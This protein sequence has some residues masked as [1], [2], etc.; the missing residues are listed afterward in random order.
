MKIFSVLIVALLIIFQAVGF[1]AKGT[2]SASGEYLMSDYDTP[3]IAEAIALDFAKQ[4][5][6]EQAGI[7]LESYSRSANFKLE[8]DEIKTV[9]SSKVEVLKK[10]ITRKPQRDGRILLRADIKATV[11][12][13]ELDN[14]LA[15][16]R[17]QRQGQ[18]QR[19]KE[20]QEMNAKIK[21]DI[22]TLQKKLAAIRNEVKDNDLI[23][24][25][26]RI[27]REFLSKQKVEEFAYKPFENEE[28]KY[29]ITRIKYDTTLIDE[30]IKFNPKNT[31]AYIL[32]AFFTSASSSNINDIN[33]ALFLTSDSKTSA[34]LYGFRALKYQQNGDLNRALEDYNKAI[35]LDPKS[36]TSYQIRASFYESRLKDYDKALADYTAAIK[37]NPKDVDAYKARVKLYE[38]QKKYSE[39][40][41]DYKT[42]LKL[43]PEKIDGFNY[44]NIGDMYKEL[45]N[46]SNALEW[47][48]K[49]INLE[50]EQ[51]FADHRVSAYLSRALIY[52]EQ[53]EH[54]K[55]IADCDKGIE[56]A[57]SASGK[58]NATGLDS[59]LKDSYDILISVLEQTKQQALNAKNE[60]KILTDKYDNIN[61]NDI[62]ALMERAQ[63]YR[64][65]FNKNYNNEYLTLAIKDYT[66]VLE[67][68]PKNQL[69]LYERA[70][71]YCLMSEYNSAVTDFSA[72]IKLNPT[73][74]YGSVYQSRGWTYEQLGDLEKALADYDKALELNPD[75]EY[76]KENRQRV[77]DKIKK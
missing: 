61:T 1:A 32:K 19:Y 11:D 6:A 15:Q 54:D 40:I 59:L 21:R 58:V 20:L 68:D 13:S 26:E 18:I 27:N 7:Y 10:N 49:A 29:D 52:E 51:T 55:A 5:A 57:K 22:D 14:F 34:T 53:G 36:S 43:A 63:A 70:W 12:T 48:T 25:Q 73:Y 46:Y 62:R 56:L 60:T 28:V 66:R 72:L 24:E 65:A 4:N 17:A 39:A 74:E 47:Y 8:T 2:F 67:L 30:A 75:N 45:K 42:I 44:T 35:Q 77:L 76:V 9:A 64:D 33:K 41:D 69:A 31:V 37:L 3:E 50:P 23:V 16:E 38:S 71:A